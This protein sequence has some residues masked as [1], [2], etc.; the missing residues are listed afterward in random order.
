MLH[1]GAGQRVLEAAEVTHENLMG[2][3]RIEHQDL[4]LSRNE[5]AHSAMFAFILTEG[6]EQYIYVY[7]VYN[8]WCM[9]TYL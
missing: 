1:I 4:G 5:N 6:S 2:Q 8:I 9:Y 7:M 3:L